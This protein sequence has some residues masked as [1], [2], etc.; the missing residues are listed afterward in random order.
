LAL[1]HL[2]IAAMLAVFAPTVVAVVTISK[3]EA[4]ETVTKKKKKPVQKKLDSGVKKN[5]G[6]PRPGEPDA[7]WSDQCIFLYNVYGRKPAF[8]GKYGRG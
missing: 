7:G 2:I 1:R 6:A 8:C 5:F 4:A 3:A